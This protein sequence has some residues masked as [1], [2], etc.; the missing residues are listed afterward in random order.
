MEMGPTSEDQF[1]SDLHLQ[2]STALSCGSFNAAGCI[3]SG[4]VVSESGSAGLTST[5]VT[6][7]YLMHADYGKT[8]RPPKDFAS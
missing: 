5:K 2:G 4:A 7:A 1:G 8:I 3:V 6:T